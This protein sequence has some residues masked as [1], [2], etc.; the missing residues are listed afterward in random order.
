MMKVKEEWSVIYGGDF[1][2]ARMSHEFIPEAA[3]S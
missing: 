2:I 1:S 3:K